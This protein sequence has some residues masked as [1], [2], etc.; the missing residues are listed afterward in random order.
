MGSFP[1]IHM[2]FNDGGRAGFTGGGYGKDAAKYI[3]EIE[4]DHHK[5][6]QY[7]KKHGGKK[8]FKQYMRESMSK[9]FAGGGIAGLSG[10]DPEGAMT[11]S[12]NP[13]SQGLSYLFNRGKKT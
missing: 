8:S 7:Y 3:K 13:D 11:R 1:D 6:Y 12:M 2:W 10:G 4:T 9:Y 5:G